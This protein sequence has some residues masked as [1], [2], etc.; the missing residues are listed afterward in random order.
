[1]QES[2]SHL[3]EHESPLAS[4]A[5]V[6]FGADG[7]MEFDFRHCGRI[8]LAIIQAAHARHLAL[9]PD[10]TLPVLMLGDHIGGVDYDAQRF[11][12]SDSVVRTTS[13]LA[14]VVRSF[15]ERHLA[16]LF[17]MYHRP[18]FPTRVFDNEAEARDWLRGFL[19][20]E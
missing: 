3:P 7:I 6:T 11:G 13:A 4:G 1:M 15:L 12:S 5:I 8:T 20:Q 10:R 17:L 2:A 14:L 19:N 9:C 16:R 18:P